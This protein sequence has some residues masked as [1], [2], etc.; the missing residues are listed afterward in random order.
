MNCQ[1]SVCSL[2]SV[3]KAG[4]E[5][6]I[7]MKFRD[8]ESALETADSSPLCLFKT[9]ET[10]I[11]AEYHRFSYPAGMVLRNKFSN[12]PSRGSLRLGIARDNLRSESAVRGRCFHLPRAGQGCSSRVLFS[13]PCFVTVTVLSK[14]SPRLLSWLGLCG[15][16][17]DG[18]GKSRRAGPIDTRLSERQE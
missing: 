6:K 15:G 18:S 4:D 17:A 10:A 5:E 16:A 11:S 8:P 14:P 12:G 7:S 9:A 2:L 3:H 13:L 1:E